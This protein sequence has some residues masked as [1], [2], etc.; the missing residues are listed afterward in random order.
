ML[1]S[2]IVTFFDKKEKFSMNFPPKCFKTTESQ[3]LAVYGSLCGEKQFLLIFIPCTGFM[4]NSGLNVSKFSSGLDPFK[5]GKKNKL[6]EFFS[7]RF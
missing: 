2:E 6:S 7:A 3:S 4:K 1:L 5:L